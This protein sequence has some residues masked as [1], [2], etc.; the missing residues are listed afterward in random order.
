ML[1][2]V[3][4]IHR[5]VEFT[6]KALWIPFICNGPKP[7]DIQREIFCLPPVPKPGNK[8]PKRCSWLRRLFWFTAAF[9][10]LAVRLAI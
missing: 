3:I 9:T 1:Q 2:E 8:F 5:L 10:D 7:I 6:E 4:F